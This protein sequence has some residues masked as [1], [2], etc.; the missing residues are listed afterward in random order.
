[1]KH[2]LILFDLDG[3]L[4]DPLEGIGKSFNYALKRFGYAERDFTELRNFIGPPIDEAFSQTTGSLDRVHIAELVAKFRERYGQ[5]GFSENKMYPGIREA[6]DLLHSAG[7]PLAVCTSKRKDFADKILSMFGI[8]DLFRF[9]SA[10]DVGIKKRKQI[11]EL[12]KHNLVTSSSLM[13]GDRAID[14]IAAHDNG[15]SAAGVLWGY[16][17]LFE[18]EQQ[19]PEYLFNSIE[20]IKALGF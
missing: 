2:D 11:S 14:I 8:G 18:L 20:E 6:L 5:L 13:V 10:G 17:S 16:G 1:M 9:V 19:R 12:R 3:T 7:I 15:L 4:S